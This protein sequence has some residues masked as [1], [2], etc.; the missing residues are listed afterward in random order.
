MK[1]VFVYVNEINVITLFHK[2]IQHLFDIIELNLSDLSIRWH[3]RLEVKNG[4]NKHLHDARPH[5]NNHN[6]N[7]NKVEI[8]MRTS[9]QIAAHKSVM[10]SI[11]PL[12]LLPP[13]ARD[14]IDAINNRYRNRFYSLIMFIICLSSKF[15]VQSSNCKIGDDPKKKKALD[16]IGEEWTMGT[17]FSDHNS[18]CKP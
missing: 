14:W 11:L 15:S 3:R 9:K 12:L 6:W 4:K 18:T 10:Q 17:V 5:S 8:L 13:T 1:R 2:H 16:Q 7:Q